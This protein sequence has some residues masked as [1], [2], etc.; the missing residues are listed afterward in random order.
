MI[1]I[2]C[3]GTEQSQ[4]LCSG[5]QDLHGGDAPSLQASTRHSSFSFHSS[6]APWLCPLPP[7]HLRYLFKSCSHWLTLTTSLKIRELS[8]LA[9]SNLFICSA[10]KNGIYHLLKYQIL[11]F[12][13][14]V[15]YLL[16][17]SFLWPPN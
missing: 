1:A 12:I 8:T 2:S 17:I 15:S 5:L 7:L 13:Y 16:S 6:L 10:F 11:C 3:I 4:S 9:F 14:Y